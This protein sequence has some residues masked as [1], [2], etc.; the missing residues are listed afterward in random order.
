MTPAFKAAMP[1]IG[2]SRS[3]N[4]NFK[5]LLDPGGDF[6]SETAVTGYGLGSTAPCRYSRAPARK[7]VQTGRSDRALTLRSDIKVI[8][9]PVKADSSYNI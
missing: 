8:N 3:P 9:I 4:R 7:A 2:L 6:T 5:P 1:M